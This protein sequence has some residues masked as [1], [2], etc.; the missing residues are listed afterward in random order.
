MD[1]N[2]YQWKKNKKFAD[3]KRMYNIS[4]KYQFLF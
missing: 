4:L 3:W 1:Q 2:I